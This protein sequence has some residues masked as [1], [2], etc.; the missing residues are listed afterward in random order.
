MLP[1]T[2]DIVRCGAIEVID[3]WPYPVRHLRALEYTIN[4]K[5]WVIYSNERS[6]PISCRGVTLFLLSLRNTFQNIARACIFLSAKVEE[7]PRRLETVINTAHFI[8]NSGTPANPRANRRFD[9][10]SEVSFSEFLIKSSAFD[11]LMIWLIMTYDPSN[12]EHTNCRWM[13]I[14]FITS[15]YV[16]WCKSLL[17]S[18]WNDSG[19]QERSGGVSAIWDHH[20]TNTRWVHIVID[21]LLLKICLNV[22]TNTFKLKLLTPSVT[23]FGMFQ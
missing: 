23:S 11:P 7:Q 5:L 20:P 22:T 12:K 1:L 10:N 6:T 18:R 8:L 15:W 19:I 21:Y 9:T 14:V 16:S 3:C 17:T 2:K 13:E 4:T